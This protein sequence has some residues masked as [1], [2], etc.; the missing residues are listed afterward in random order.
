MKV[1]FK[2]VPIAAA[3]EFEALFNYFADLT[4]LSVTFKRAFYFIFSVGPQF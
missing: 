3:L 1:Y 4:I 2:N